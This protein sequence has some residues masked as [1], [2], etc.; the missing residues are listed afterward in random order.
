METPGKLKT[1]LLCV[2]TLESWA[3]KLQILV[4]SGRVHMFNKYWTSY[5]FC[6][7]NYNVWFEIIVFWGVKQNNFD[8]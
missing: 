7:D 5:V 2:Y 4:V 1:R 8:V 6:S 3:T